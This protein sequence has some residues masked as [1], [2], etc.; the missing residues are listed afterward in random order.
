MESRVPDHLCCPLT[1]ELFENAVMGADNQTYSEEAIKNWLENYHERSPITNEPMT[2]SDLSPNYAIRTAVEAYCSSMM[3]LDTNPPLAPPQK[4]SVNASQTS[5]GLT[6][7]IEDSERHHPVHHILV[8]DTSS[9]MNTVTTRKNKDNIDES[10]GMSIRDVTVHGA[11]TVV[12]GAVGHEG[13][14]AASDSVTVILF[15]SSATLALENVPMTSAGKERT[16]SVLDAIKASGM[17]NIADAVRMALE[18]G[19]KERE[20][21]KKVVS[22]TLFTDGQPTLSPPR[23]ERHHLQRSIAA[24]GLSPIDVLGFGY[25]LDSGLLLDY[26]I[27]TGGSSSFIPDVQFLGTAIEHVAAYAKPVIGQNTRVYRHATDEEPL[28][29]G[30]L[31]RGQTL[32]LPPEDYDRV[33]YTQVG[34]GVITTIH[35]MTTMS[36]EKNGSTDYESLRRMFVSVTRDLALSSDPSSEYETMTAPL[37]DVMTKEWRESDPRVEGLWGML[38]SPDKDVR[39]VSEALTNSDYFDRW[40]KD[41]VLSLGRALELERC[42]NYKDSPIQSYVGKSVAPILERLDD[43][44]CDMPPPK[45]T[46]TRP[47]YRSL[48]ASPPTMSMRAVSYGGGPCFGGEGLVKMADGTSKRVDAIRAGDVVVTPL[49]AGTASVKLVLETQCDPQMPPHMTHINDLPITAYHP[50]MHENRWTFPT[51]IKKAVPEPSRRFVF[52][53]LL[54]NGHTMSINDITCITLGHGFSSNVARHPY[55][56]TSRV[57]HDLEELPVDSCGVIHAQANWILRNNVTQCVCGIVKQ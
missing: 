48:V 23:G 32:H 14:P 1:K 26:A 6:I 49:N 2:V 43:I 56:G 35:P 10:T 40:G 52:S 53:F 29:V 13:N 15:S 5:E 24:N 38:A 34:T 46:A 20:T 39:Q 42:N 36:D 54:T 50:V 9:S 8:I 17:T 31:I 22:I 19:K 28:L 25:S 51:D 16:K 21:T 45:P 12:E 41:Y 44:F 3:V 11:K 30:N 37:L 57:V 4:E 55:F 33:E 27:R 7:T 18:I 47:V